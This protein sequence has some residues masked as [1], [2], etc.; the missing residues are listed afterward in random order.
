MGYAGEMCRRYNAFHRFVLNRRPAI[1]AEDA[2][3]Y[4][5]RFGGDG[6]N[7]VGN[8]AIPKVAT[9][10]EMHERK[11][12]QRRALLHAAPHRASVIALSGIG[13]RHT[14]EVPLGKSLAAAGDENWGL[15]HT[16]RGSIW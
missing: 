16:N 6:R 8:D 3:Q 4:F 10:R 14:E 11:I 15:Y 13:E 7:A 1:V 12:L 2:L 9:S 5:Y